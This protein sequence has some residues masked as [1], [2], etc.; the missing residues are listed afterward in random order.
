MKKWAFA[1]LLAACGG[2][3]A[4]PAPAPPTPSAT[5]SEAP[6]PVASA[7]A[8]PIET[9]AP[10]APPPS[11]PPKPFA[12]NATFK[13]VVAALRRAGDSH[14]VGDCIFKGD[15]IATYDGSPALADPPADLEP[16]FASPPRSGFDAPGIKLVTSWGS[17]EGGGW[18]DLVALT[19]VPK[20]VH[21]GVT[22]VIFATD[23]GLYFGAVGHAVDAKPLDA[24]TM[25]RV[26]SEILPKAK[27]VVVS[28]EGDAPLSRVKEALAL[29]NGTKGTVVLATPTSQPGSPGKRY[30]RYDARVPK[31]TK[32]ACEDDMTD[33]RGQK[34]GSY[35]MQTMSRFADAMMA[36]DKTCGE[37][38]PPGKGG[39]IH[40]M[41]R[42]GAD[43]KITKACAETDDLGDEKVR[44]CVMDAVRKQKLPAPD[45]KKGIVNFGTA[46]VFSGKPIR[47]LCN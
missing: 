24:G 46:V 45:E 34:P 11:E 47:A 31:G 30:S 18:L 9:A 28:A 1:V 42:I 35:K 15:T 43:G 4:P 25:A 10:P 7:P 6:A 27:V 36:L 38:L 32:D 3:K 21:G 23:K 33:V 44:A 20:S 2:A 19:P 26:K 12:A 29:V 14:V 17:T 40:V 41:M 37:S 5:A 22:A 39:S 8:P 16:L 13:D